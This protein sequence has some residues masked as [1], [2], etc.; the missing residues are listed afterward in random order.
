MMNSKI[1]ILM[2]NYNGKIF[3]KNCI[4]SILEQT[5]SHFEVIIFDN[6]SIDD[7]VEFIKNNYSQDNIKL[8]V[9]KS[10]LGFAGGNNEGLKHCSGEFVVLLNNDTTVEKNWLEELFN[11]YSKA[12]NPGIVQSL[13]L[14]EGIPAKYY[15]MNGTINLLG[16]NIMRE[17]PIG[18][19]GV[20][21]ILLATGACMIFKKDL[22][23]ELNGLFPYEYFFYAEDTYFSLRTVFAGYNNYHTSKSIVHHIG[24]GSTGKVKKPFVTFCQERNR[25]LNFLL[26]FSKSFLW[27][28]SPYLIFNFFLKLLRGLLSKNYSLNGL[29]KSYSWMFSNIKWIRN[30]RSDLSKYKTI[31]E[32]DV[33]KLISGKIFNGENILEKFINSFS[34]FYCRLV[35]IKVLELQKK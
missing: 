9:S 3:L 31:N 29:F 4:D 35:S 28:Y 32:D 10:N 17:F 6:N 8:V 13:V 14:T 27:K 15:E 22:V 1:S 5:Y 24:S 11:A 20:G 33:L 25:L 23:S 18:S 34:I 30:K 7:S 2:L 16:H 12:Q 26:L 19:D 21:K